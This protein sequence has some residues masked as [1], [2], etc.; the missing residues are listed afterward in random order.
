MLKWFKL[1]DWGDKL[2]DIRLDI[3]SKAERE[4]GRWRR[5]NTQKAAEEEEEEEGGEEVVEEVEEEEEE[6]IVKEG[7][8][9][10]EGKLL[11]DKMAE[12]GDRTENVELLNDEAVGPINNNKKKTKRK[13]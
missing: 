7:E 2:S 13:K 10:E 11:S 5:K 6:E 9:E 3:K 4:G 12:V 8:E 1:W